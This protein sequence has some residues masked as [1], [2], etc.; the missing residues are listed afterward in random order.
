MSD[1]AVPGVCGGGREH[2]E[3]REEKIIKQVTKED[4]PEPSL[5]CK[6]S[7]SAIFFPLYLTLTIPLSKQKVKGKRLLNISTPQSTSL[8]TSGRTRLLSIASAILCQDQNSPGPVQTEE[9]GSIV[10]GLDRKVIIWTIRLS[11]NR[12]K[13]SKRYPVTGQLQKTYRKTFVNVQ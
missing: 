3:N 6:S 8:Q 13:L 10:S 11:S 5:H 1:Q 12:D 2:E 7:G 4:F 9:E